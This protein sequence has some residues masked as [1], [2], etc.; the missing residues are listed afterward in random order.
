MA[1]GIDDALMS[2]AAG[3]SLTDTVVKTVQS[4]RRKG[5]QIDI[6]QL[7]EEV[8]GT[9]LKRIKDADT[10]LMQFERTLVER[11]VDTSKKLQEVIDSTSVWQPFEQ[12]RLR[13]Y[14]SSFNAL[15]DAAYNAVD[16]IAALL[17]CKNQTQQMGSAVVE[18]AAAKHELHSRLLNAPS[19][20]NAI[21]LLR[22]ELRR[23]KALLMR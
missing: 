15:A 7:I 10:A 18:S 17:R 20:K 4:H 22:A 11:G 21:D 3:I 8:R 2:A 23:Q 12:Y 6:E 5:Q 1:F 19:F 16:D 9:A 14:K 13:G